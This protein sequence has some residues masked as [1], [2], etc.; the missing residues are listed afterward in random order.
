MARWYAR[1]AVFALELVAATRRYGRRTALRDVDLALAPGVALGLLGPNGAGKT[2]A[3][4]LLLGFTRPTRGAARLRGRDPMD[5]GSRRGVG[6]LPERLRLPGAMSLGRFL[7]LSGALAGLAGASLEREVL[8]VAEAT[9]VRE[10][11]GE[12]CDALS[13][14]LAQRVGFA[15]AL[16]GAPD[17]LLL[18]E[19]T[20]GLDPLGVRDARDWILSARARGAT[21][22]VSSHV[23]SEVERTCERVVILHEGAV[24]AA[25][26]LA[27]LLHPGETLEDAFV[28]AV[29]G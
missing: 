8:A 7:R 25:G 29:R 27:E 5:P 2:T 11:L 19:P 22:L 14:G 23:L 1:A 16:L 26:P 10:R 21:V 6:Y 18:D 28:R 3:L 9:G 17:L 12:R 15:S 20:S 24:A 13:K 4:R